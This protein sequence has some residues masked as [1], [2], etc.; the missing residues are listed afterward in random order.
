MAVNF[1]SGDITG[2]IIKKERRNIGD[3]PVL[4]AE[5]LAIQ[6]VSYQAIQKY[7]KVI[8]ESNS[9]VAIQAIMRKSI[10]PKTFVF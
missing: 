7:M 10:P 3:T 1:V 5:T 6:N 8:I 4:V 2:R 9:L